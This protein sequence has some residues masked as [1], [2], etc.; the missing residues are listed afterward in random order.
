MKT[1]FGSCCSTRISLGLPLE[2][3]ARN[4]CDRE[5]AVIGAVRCGSLKIARWPKGER[6]LLPTQWPPG[7][8][9][10]WSNQ[11]SNHLVKH[12]MRAA[13]S[14]GSGVSRVLGSGSRVWVSKF[15]F[16]VWGLGFQVSGSWCRTFRGYGSW[17]RGA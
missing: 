1:P 2:R 11:W 10:S 12:R 4:L 3:G 13:R 17:F 6:R 16:Q 14:S 7:S 15:G 5:A 8:S 9:G